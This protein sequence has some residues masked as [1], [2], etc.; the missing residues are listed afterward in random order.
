[1]AVDGADCRT[2]QE[3]VARISLIIPCS[4]KRTEPGVAPVLY[5]SKVIGRFNTEFSV[6][7]GHFPCTFPLKQG[8]SLETRLQQT[9]TTATQSSLRR[10]SLPETLYFPQIHLVAAWLGMQFRKITSPNDCIS[11]SSSDCR[12]VDVRV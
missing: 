12:T 3:F 2:W 10:R 4:N 9:V 7:G 6:G 1:M 11:S 8:F 5:N